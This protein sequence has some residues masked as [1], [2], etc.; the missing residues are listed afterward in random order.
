[1]K[2]SNRIIGIFALFL[3]SILVSQLSAYSA[4]DFYQ[5]GDVISL[6]WSTTS[7]TRGDAIVKSTSKATGGI[8]G[9]A[10]SGVASAG[11]T[12][13]VKT[14]GVVY[15][16]VTASSPVGNIAVGDYIFGSV[17]GN[18]EVCTTVL[19]NINTGLIFG[20]ALEAV[21]ATTTAEVYSTIKV[22]LL[23]PSHL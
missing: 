2:N 8:T 6:T 9:V 3:V 7:P 18:V 1:M 11:E 22:K 10:I 23:Q 14:G 16:P 13:Q 21:T 12:V 4:G 20:Q 17:A 5:D 15:L 19:S